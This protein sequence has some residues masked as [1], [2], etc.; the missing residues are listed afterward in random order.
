[1]ATKL[2]VLTSGGDAPGMNAA[3]RSVVRAAMY[4]DWNVIG[5]ERGFAGL[6]EEDFRP[7]FRRS[8]GG[9]IHRGGTMLRTARCEAFATA[10]GQ[11]RAVAFLQRIGVDRVI[12][13]GGDGSMAGARALAQ[14]GMPTVTIPGTIDNDMAGTEYTIGFDSAINTA[15]QAVNMIRDTAY[16]HERI[17]I[18]EVMG[19]H[20]GHI[21]LETAA[22]C[23]AEFVLVPELPFHMDDLT[24]KLRR[25]RYGGKKHGIIIVAEGVMSGYELA[26]R[27]RQA[28]EYEPSITVLGYIQRG[29]APSAFDVTTA[30]RM[31]ELAVD[32]AAAPEAGHLIAVRNHRI[33]AVPYEEIDGAKRGLDMELY[34]LID[35]LSM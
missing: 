33:V 4:R 35:E 14:A 17:A 18:V 2:A 9:I 27:L 32:M 26:E 28:T 34:Q 22:A 31:G 25:C 3:L 1:M 23:G 20:S 5:I 8:V 19:R 16:S 12:V 7:L 24:E 13:I 11:R 30:S 10:E 6:L 15:M 21:A 29:G